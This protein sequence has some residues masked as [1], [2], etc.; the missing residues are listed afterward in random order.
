MASSAS[1]HTAGGSRDAADVAAR[2][3]LLEQL[4]AAFDPLREEVATTRAQLL[5]ARLEDH[6]DDA[7]GPLV[8]DRSQLVSLLGAVDKGRTEA[9]EGDRLIVQHAWVGYWWRLLR[10]DMSAP[11]ASYQADLLACD[12]FD[13]QT[14]TRPGDRDAHQKKLFFIKKNFF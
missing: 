4:Q 7:E 8:V 12:M 1:G 9:T 10:G 5:R 13:G 3:A 11:G 14:R 2:P 6:C